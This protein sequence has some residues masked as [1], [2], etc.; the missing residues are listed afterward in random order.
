M[1]RYSHEKTIIN[2]IELIHATR[3][4]EVYPFILDDMIGTPEK[5]KSMSYKEIKK[6][7]E[8][9]EY[10]VLTEHMKVSLLT[11]IPYINEHGELDYKY[12]VFDEFDSLDDLCNINRLKNIS[13]ISIN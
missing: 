4:Y 11:E 13:L 6:M 8:Y 2:R 1:P 3:I 7:K 9:V 5:V 12:I 10:I